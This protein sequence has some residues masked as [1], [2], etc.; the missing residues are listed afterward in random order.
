MSWFQNRTILDLSCRN[1]VKLEVDGMKLL[2]YNINGD[3]STYSLDEI[4]GLRVYNNYLKTLPRLPDSISILF[5]DN[6]QLQSLPKLPK[7]LHTLCCSY[8]QI[9]TIKLRK[10][11]NTLMCSGNPIIF[12]APIPGGRPTRCVVP[13]QLSSLYSVKHYPKYCNRYVVYFYLITFLILDAKIS[14]V[15]VNNEHFWFPGEI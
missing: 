6:N 11:P 7:Y 1:L 10:R 14:P 2:A 12:I 15:I 5:C 3:V 13:D 8:N 4:D 9:Q